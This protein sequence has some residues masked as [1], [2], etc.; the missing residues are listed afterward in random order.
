MTLRHKTLEGKFM[1]RTNAI[2]LRT[3][4]LEQALSDPTWRKAVITFAATKGGPVGIAI[5]RAMTRR[6]NQ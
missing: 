6:A 3:P 1:S 2:T 4:T 5:I